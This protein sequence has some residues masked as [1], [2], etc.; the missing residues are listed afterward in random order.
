MLSV[1][2]GSCFGAP[3]LGWEGG[4]GQVAESLPG[5]PAF[6]NLTR[7]LVLLLL[8]LLPTGLG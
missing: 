3:R 4:R 2:T 7:L 5:G 8:L 1:G 6:C